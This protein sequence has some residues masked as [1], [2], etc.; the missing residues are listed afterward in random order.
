[1]HSLRGVKTT[2]AT[3]GGETVDPGEAHPTLTKRTSKNQV[4]I[5]KAVA[6]QFPGVEHFEVSVERG[7]IILSP[8]LPGGSGGGA[9]EAGLA[10]DYRRGRCRGHPL[11]APLMSCPLRVV[12]D[13]NVLVSALL[14][15]G[16]LSWLREA[17]HGGRVRPVLCRATASELL[18][19]LAYPKFRLTELEINALLADLLPTTETVD[20]G[21]RRGR[22]L[23]RC[24]DRDDQVFLVLAQVAK[25][26][27]L[28]TVDRHLLALASQTSFPIWE[29]STL[30]QRLSTSEEE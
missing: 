26:D 1:M 14:F 7:R 3:K 24:R 29:V 5:P 13:T 27:A 8:V 30:R 17:W 16:R 28:V 23:P 10:G 22:G 15:G 12:L 6:D 25:V 19:V 9:G 21:R 18:R 4:T 20:I 11:G 2:K